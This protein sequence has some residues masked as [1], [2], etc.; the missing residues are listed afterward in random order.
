MIKSLQRIKH[1]FFDL[2][3]TLWDFHNNSESSLN[4]IFN[5][6]ALSHSFHNFLLFHH[7]YSH[8]NRIL[9]ESY[10]E[11]NID[12]DTLLYKRFY[13]TL[14]HVH[15]DDTDMA[16]EMAEAYMEI[17]ACQTR[18]M[19]KAK[20]T[21]DYLCSRGYKCHIITNGFS[22]IQNR[23][24]Q[25]SGLSPYIDTV[26]DS[27]EAKFTKPDKQ[28][29]LYALNKANTNIQSSVMIGDDLLTDIQGAI[30]S[31]MKFIHYDISPEYNTNTHPTIHH[32][33]AL[34]DI[35]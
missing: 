20:D 12:R 22:D 35:L 5:E 6:F 14:R 32:L 1:I 2:D 15:I 10:Y 8:H 28:I 24:I 33:D 4:Q 9:W 30:N 3:N 26:T 19:P 11:G 34:K 27:E 29:F 25:N 31:G 17:S 18:L 13:L 21:L 7:I 23:K 16:K